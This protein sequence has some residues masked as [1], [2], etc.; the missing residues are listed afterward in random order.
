[1]KTYREEM[2]C[3]AEL[4]DSYEDPF[5]QETLEDFRAENHTELLCEIGIKEL[6]FDDFNLNEGE[7]DEQY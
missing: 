4:L 1:M 5:A 3:L 7:Y 2:Q 6:D